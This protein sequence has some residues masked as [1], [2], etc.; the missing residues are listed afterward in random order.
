VRKGG[1]WGINLL[2]QQAYRLQ[3]FGIDIRPQYPPYFSD[4]LGWA[5]APACAGAQHVHDAA[6]HPPIV[7]AMR[8]SAAAW[9]PPSARVF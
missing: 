9:R 6:D 3:D 7:D 4:W 5:I 2:G 1:E 8:P